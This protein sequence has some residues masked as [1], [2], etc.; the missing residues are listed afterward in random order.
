MPAGVRVTPEDVEAVAR[1]GQ[2]RLVWDGVPVDVFLNNLPLHEAAAKSL[3][4][5]EFS[6]TYLDTNRSGRLVSASQM[7]G[8]ISK[9]GAEAGVADPVERERIVAAIAKVASEHGYARMTVDQVVQYAGVPRD[10]FAVHFSGKEQGIVA[11]QDA[12]LEHL[13]LEVLGVC[14][15]GREWPANV[16]AALAAGLAFLAETSALARVFAIEAAG[17]LA[18]NERQFSTLDGFADLLRDG[19]RHFPEAADMPPEMERA[20][21]G[22]IA[23][24]VTDRLLAEQPQALV[25]LGP[26]MAE[27]I[28]TPY[29]GQVAAKRAALD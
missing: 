15:E 8:G 23:S 14:E 26:Q 12:F 3:S 24:I 4:L 13:W 11:A 6:C 9:R 18:A 10:A 1:S 27:F 21:I 17:S 2:T 5:G 28:L 16:R 29:I 20:L 19:R 7:A 22:G 25:D